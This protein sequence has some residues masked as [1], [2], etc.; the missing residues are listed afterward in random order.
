MSAVSTSSPSKAEGPGLPLAESFLLESPRAAPKYV[1]LGESIG[2]YAVRAFRPGVAKYR[3][4]K[5]ALRVRLFG[6]FDLLV[7]MLLAWQ[8][9]VELNLCCP[10]CRAAQPITMT[11]FNNVNI[12]VNTIFCFV[13]LLVWAGQ[14]YI[15]CQGSTRAQMQSTVKRI[16]WIHGVLVLVRGSAQAFAAALIPG[17][18]SLCL[19]KGRS[20]PPGECL[21]LTLQTVSMAAV[22]TMV[23]YYGKNQEGLLLGVVDC[24]PRWVGLRWR[25]EI[26]PP[27]LWYFS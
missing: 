21:A 2:D 17:I 26:E 23:L 22:V 19:F 5:Y 25:S 1:I 18:F 3:H 20:A 24:Y 4:N 12:G 15:L 11:I 10:G 8:S 14:T 9:I 27:P 7:T 13:Q 6:F 16:N